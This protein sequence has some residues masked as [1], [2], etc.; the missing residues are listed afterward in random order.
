MS[1]IVEIANIAIDDF[2]TNLPIL[3][4]PI[5]YS[6]FVDTKIPLPFG[7]A[8]HLQAKC[9]ITAGHSRD[10]ANGIGQDI[11]KCVHA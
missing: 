3:L 10:T 7:I 9:L 6:A 5:R 8:N 2:S 4:C 1:Q 11:F